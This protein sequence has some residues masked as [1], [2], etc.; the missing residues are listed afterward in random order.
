M[1]KQEYLSYGFLQLPRIIAVSRKFTHAEK[2]II[3]CVIDMMWQNKDTMQYIGSAWPSNEYLQLMCNVGKVTVIN[4]KKKVKG[5]GLFDIIK[6]MNASDV[7]KLN[8]IPDVMIDEYE[9][10]LDSMRERKDKKTIS[11]EE[12]A[13]IIDGMDTSELTEFLLENP[14]YGRAI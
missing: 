4:C 14:E 3:A 9:E 6:R 12:L 2:L 8:R 5:I 10:F 13:G 11:N 7:W 1:S